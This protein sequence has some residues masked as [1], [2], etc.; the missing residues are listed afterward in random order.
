[1]T[2]ELGDIVAVFGCYF[3]PLIWICGSGFKNPKTVGSGFKQC[4]PLRKLLIKQAMKAKISSV[5]YFTFK[6]YFIL[7]YRI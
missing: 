7:L 1:V 4:Y 5:I 2:P 6:N 3:A